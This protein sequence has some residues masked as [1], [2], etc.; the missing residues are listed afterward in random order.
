MS[1][2]KHLDKYNMPAYE[3]CA[4]IRINKVDTDS[5][6]TLLLEKGI[7]HVMTGRSSKF[8]CEDEAEFRLRSE[9]KRIETDENVISQRALNTREE[10]GNILLDDLEDNGTILDND[11]IDKLMHRYFEEEFVESEEGD[12]EI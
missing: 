5:V 12:K 1:D 2:N 10:Y 9:F 8:F 6:D 4:F 7:P 11:W 3:D